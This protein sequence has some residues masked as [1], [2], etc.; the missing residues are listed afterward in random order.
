MAEDNRGNQV[1]HNCHIS[2]KFFLQNF[3]KDKSKCK[4]LYWF[5]IDWIHRVSD[6][7]EQTIKK[8]AIIENA[9]N[10]ISFDD[11]SEGDKEKFRYDDSLEREYGQG[12]EQELGK[13]WK[14]LI[15][16]RLKKDPFVFDWFRK[17][18][19]LG[20]L[21]LLLEKSIYWYLFD[22]YKGDT[23]ANPSY[24]EKE[25]KYLSN[26]ECFI[27]KL[28]CFSQYAIWNPDFLLWDEYIR[29][30][31]RSAESNYCTCDVPIHLILDNDDSYTA[32]R[33]LGSPPFFEEIKNSIK[34]LYF[35]ISRDYCIYIA[36]DSVPSDEIKKFNNDWVLDAAL[37]YV[38]CSNENVLKDIRQKI[39]KNRLKRQTWCAN[40]FSNAL[41]TF[42]HVA[43]L[44]QGIFH[45]RWNWELPEMLKE[46]QRS[47]K[48]K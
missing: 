48:E 33:F 35:P 47:L 3:S 21:K 27:K 2:P 4:L 32:L 13:E 18:N 37:K 22:E 46:I 9:Y 10:V 17:K 25:K 1:T 26:N 30:I 16:G 43:F 23:G 41:N 40:L 12:R 44:Q 36:K 20:V 42:Y 8:I 29:W 19:V 34:I 28:F 39:Q 15:E 7:Q 45:K 5:E 24:S 14:N 38:I 6:S 11:F 31:L